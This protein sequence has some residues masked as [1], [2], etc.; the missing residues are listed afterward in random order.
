[1]ADRWLEQAREAYVNNHDS[2]TNVALQDLIVRY[3]KQYA[4]LDAIADRC[5]GQILPTVD[6]I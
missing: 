3:Y 6:K 2:K 4:P 1:M 5:A